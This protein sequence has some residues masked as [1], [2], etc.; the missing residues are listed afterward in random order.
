M[1]Q[2]RI[3]LLAPAKN[4]DQ[5]K[6]AI[7]CGADAVYIGP[8]K[9]GARARVGNSIEDIEKLIYYADLYYAKVYATINTLLF[10]NE[11]ATAVDLI[12]QLYD[13]GI[14]GIIIQDMGLLEYDLPPVPFIASTQCFVNR[15]DKAK[16]FQEAGFQRIILPRE[17]S[18]VQIAEI[19]EATPDI[20]LEYFVHGA[21]CVGYSGQC[22]MSY[23][24]GG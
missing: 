10:D 8:S 1:K 19:R 22:Y 24:L 18:A 20:E 16:F 17:L 12:Y 11:L 3:E 5:G 21:L 6:L 2:K 9:F 13:I 7:S 15:P 23:A 14:S 4:F